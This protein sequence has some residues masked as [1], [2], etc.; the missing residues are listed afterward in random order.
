MRVLCITLSV[1]LSM[2]A[3]GV[4]GTVSGSHV[5]GTYVE[6]RTADVYTGPCFANSEA[7]LV[8]KMAVFGWKVDE[9]NWEGVSLDGLGV[10]GVV[11]A[12]DTL[13]SVTGNPYPVK[14]VL[15]VDEK[16]DAEQRLALRAFAQRMSGDLLQDIVS[17][18]YRPIELEIENNNVHTA[19]AR[20]TAGEL[21]EI[22][23]RAI[24]KGDHFCSNEQVWYP[25]LT[26]VDH[27]MPAYTL[28]HSYQ[29]KGL[30]TRWNLPD[31]RSAFVASFQFSD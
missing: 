11:R 19:T 6:A 30:D 28:A 26:R 31:E 3:I 10:I 2:S 7:G 21:A 14:S 9:G 16:A 18:E 15:I 20:L 4:A 29:G 1:F 17:V 12:R 22:R 27:A 24:T 23:T 8:G 13:G 5:Q 25:P